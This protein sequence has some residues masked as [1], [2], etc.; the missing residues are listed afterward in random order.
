MSFSNYREEGY[1]GFLLDFFFIFLKNK[2]IL[3]KLALLD[4]FIAFLILAEMS[5]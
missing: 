3:K 4:K 2:A 1:I 5:I